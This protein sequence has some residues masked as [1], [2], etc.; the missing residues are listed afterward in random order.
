MIAVFPTR[1]SPATTTVH[2]VSLASFMFVIS[3]FQCFRFSGNF[4]C[5]KNK[6]N[7]KTGRNK[8]LL[9]LFLC[10]TDDVHSFLF[11]LLKT[12][13]L[14]HLLFCQKNIILFFSP[15]FCC[16][17]CNS[18][19]FYVTHNTKRTKQYWPLQKRS[20]LTHT[21]YNQTISSSSQI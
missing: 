17:V 1:L 11:S 3:M 13:I 5:K 10:F 6:K 15:L 16:S 20:T 9:L 19:N 4:F 12:R 2:S 21:F 8:L 18:I 7:S 14:S